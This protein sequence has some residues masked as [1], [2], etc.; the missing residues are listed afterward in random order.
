MPALSDSDAA[1]EDF[2]RRFLQGRDC[3]QLLFCRGYLA[4]SPTPRPPPPPRQTSARL[5]T[6][7]TGRPGAAAPH[8]SVRRLL[9]L[10]LAVPPSL[11]RRQP[12]PRAEQLR[13]DGGDPTDL[14]LRHVQRRPPGAPVVVV[15]YRRFIA[16]YRLRSV[17][18]TT[19]CKNISSV[20]LRVRK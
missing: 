12:L 19:S 3:R 15:V 16:Q 10:R 6:A 7:A 20:Y 8:R 18:F 9:P 14:R 4:A 13:P 1:L 5:S 17:G 2:C 11:S